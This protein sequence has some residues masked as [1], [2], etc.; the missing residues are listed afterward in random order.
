MDEISREP[1]ADTTTARGVKDQPKG[2]RELLVH[3][4][5]QVRED[6][7]VTESKPA[8]GGDEAPKPTPD[9]RRVATEVLTGR[10]RSRYD[11]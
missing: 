1:P 2:P 4:R 11:G 9:S 3:E 10:G 6:L 8:A 5:S 7:A